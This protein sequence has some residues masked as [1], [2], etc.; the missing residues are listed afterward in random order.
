MNTQTAIKLN[1]FK[2]IDNAIETAEY[3]DQ[4]FSTA[5]ERARFALECF[6][7][8]Y[9]CDYEKKRTPN[10]TKRIAEW[11]AGLPTVCT[12]PFEN[13]EIVSIGYSLGM[14]KREKDEDSFLESWFDL[15]AWKLVQMS[16]MK[17]NAEVTFQ[18]FLAD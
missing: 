12:V 5:A 16:E 2:I 7:G 6:E 11:L 14:I 8:E 4:E 13:H 18:K 1:L 15:M 10:R 9:E 3:T 17:K